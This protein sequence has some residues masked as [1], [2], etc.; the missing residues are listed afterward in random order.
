MTVAGIELNIEVADS[1][2]GKLA[3]AR[4][5]ENNPVAG[6]SPEQ[7]LAVAG[8]VEDNPAACPGAGHHDTGLEW[9]TQHHIERERVDIGRVVVDVGGTLEH[10]RI[11]DPEVQQQEPHN[12]ADDRL[13]LEQERRPGHQRTAGPVGYSWM[14]RCTGPL[15]A[16]RG[17]MNTN[18]AT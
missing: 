3:V 4:F 5:V 7:K 14:R 15:P 10:T 12:Q 9:C 2:K 17:I 18:Q 8:F 1:P 11:A 16:L 6:S 13:V